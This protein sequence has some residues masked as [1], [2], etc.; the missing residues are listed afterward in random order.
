MFKRLRNLRLHCA[1]QIL[2]YSII[3]FITT[4][5]I[6]IIVI[7]VTIIESLCVDVYV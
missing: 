5:I 7:I 2:R 4:I 6:I 1:I 3:I